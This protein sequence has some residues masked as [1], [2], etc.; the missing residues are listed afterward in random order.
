MSESRSLG[1]S[2]LHSDL[3][4]HKPFRRAFNPLQQ[5][6]VF[7]YYY[8]QK[9]CTEMN[10][11]STS[12]KWCICLLLLTTTVHRN[13]H[14]SSYVRILHV[15]NH[16]APLH[17]HTYN[18][19]K[20]NLLNLRYEKNDVWAANGTMELLQTNVHTYIATFI[21]DSIF[22]INNFNEIERC[23]INGTWK[24][25]LSSALYNG[26]ASNILIHTYIVTI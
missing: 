8:R 21:M 22:L 20:D 7:V 12:V 15:S 25:F 23:W 4:R 13:A 11:K 1:N 17:L 2:K 5:N 26:F 14:Q 16:A 6:D 3:S 10:V 18:S 19:L 24:W 9:P